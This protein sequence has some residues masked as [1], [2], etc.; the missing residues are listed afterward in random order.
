[1]ARTTNHLSAA[2]ARNAENFRQMAAKAERTGKNVGGYTLDQLRQ[3]EA[4][5]CRYAA[6][7]PAEMRAHQASVRARIREAV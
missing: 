6:M 2:Y 4:S 7:N 5:F 1:M 3:L